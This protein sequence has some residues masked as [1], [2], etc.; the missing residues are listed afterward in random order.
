[1]IKT[2]VRRVLLG[3]IILIIWPTIIFFEWILDSQYP[4]ANDFAK[5]IWYGGRSLENGN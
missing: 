2:I 1:M 5:Y 4:T 3:W